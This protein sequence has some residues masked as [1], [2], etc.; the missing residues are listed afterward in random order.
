MEVSAEFGYLPDKAE[1]FR[2]LGVGS[3]ALSPRCRKSLGRSSVAGVYSSGR[4]WYT[5]L[6]LVSVFLIVV[7]KP[8]SFLSSSFSPSGHKTPVS[9]YII[10]PCVFKHNIVL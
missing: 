7:A 6:A 3:P 5:Q 1:E 8:T 2:M 9:H 10:V 4:F